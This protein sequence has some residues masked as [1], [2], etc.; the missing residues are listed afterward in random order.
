MFS[1]LSTISN[2]IKFYPKQLDEGSSHYFQN[3]FQSKPFQNQIGKYSQEA[4]FPE[5]RKM[6]HLLKILS[7]QCVVLNL[8]LAHV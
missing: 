6:N 8:H 1:S 2:M 3:Y 7:V 5:R 4:D